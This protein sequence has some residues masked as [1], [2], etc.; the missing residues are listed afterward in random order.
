MA[1]PE[2]SRRVARECLGAHLAY[3]S[4]T[5]REG[6][7]GNGLPANQ[8]VSLATPSHGIPE[9]QSTVAHQ[10]PEFLDLEAK[11]PPAPEDRRDGGR[12]RA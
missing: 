3:A 4:L 9:T 5:S 11:V 7:Q 10:V 1:G 8:A 12:P 2:D 6:S